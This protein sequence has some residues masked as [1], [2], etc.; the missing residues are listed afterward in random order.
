VSFVCPDCSWL[1]LA[2]K[3]LQLC[4]KHL[5]LALCRSS[6]VNKSCHFFLVPSQSS[7]TP[8][9][10]FIVL[11]TRERAPTP[12]P[13]VVF[14]LGLTFESRKE[15]GV[16]HTPSLKVIYPYFLGFFSLSFGHNS[17]SEWK[18]QDQYGYPCF[19]SFPM[20]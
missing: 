20:V 16:C 1:V 5:V 15:L 19:E 8:F 10:P 7:S 2:P 11:W 9:Y 17:S 6:W 3:V 13:F 14:S 18:M 4:I 12:C